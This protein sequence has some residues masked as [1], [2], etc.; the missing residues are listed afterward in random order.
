MF[1]LMVN[2]V[3]AKPVDGGDKSKI[4]I[5]LLIGLNPEATIDGD[6]S[7]LT[8]VEL[9]YVSTHPEEM[10]HNGTLVLAPPRFPLPISV[11]TVHLSLPERYEYKFSGD[12]GT[13]PSGRLAYALPST[14]S[15][16]KG[17]RVVEKGYKFT[18]I[19]DFWPEDEQEKHGSVIKISTPRTGRSFHFHRLLVVDI[20]LALNATFSEPAVTEK[21]SGLLSWLFG[22][23]GLA[24]SLSNQ[25]PDAD[26]Q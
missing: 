17:K 11:V 12:F 1:S 15:Y 24:R 14:F 3:P 26:I 16:K 20:P 19:D 7:M 25:Q 2:S 23:F 13:K 18:S 9:N 10:G 5:P 22:V 8:S 6:S 21:P 4:L